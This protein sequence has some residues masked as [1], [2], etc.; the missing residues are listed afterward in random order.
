[1]HILKDYYLSSQDT[2]HML[3]V[4]LQILVFWA[5]VKSWG[6]FTLLF[7]P[8]N[9]GW[10]LAWYNIIN[11]GHYNLCEGWELGWLKN[12]LIVIIN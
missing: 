4:K 12:Q 2:L 11:V 5:F 3:Y 7:A 9:V 8:I 1:M 6:M 10:K